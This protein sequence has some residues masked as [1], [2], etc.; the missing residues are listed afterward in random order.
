MHFL[1]PRSKLK[2]F[3]LNELAISTKNFFEEL[4][5]TGAAK[6]NFEIAEINERLAEL[7]QLTKGLQQPNIFAEDEKTRLHIAR[8]ELIKQ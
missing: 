2:A 1:P 7:N 5:A 3:L 6:L 4:N 8:N